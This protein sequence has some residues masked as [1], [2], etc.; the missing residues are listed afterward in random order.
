[1]FAFLQASQIVEFLT[2]FDEMLTYLN[3]GPS[4][5]NLVYNRKEANDDIDLNANLVQKRG[6]KRKLSPSN[7]FF[8]FLCRVR[9]GLFELDIA[10]Q[11]Q[12][13]S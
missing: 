2:R 7:Q 1:M 12:H 10:L 6:R 5:E 3:V 4:G 9:L 13:F 8:L 11:I